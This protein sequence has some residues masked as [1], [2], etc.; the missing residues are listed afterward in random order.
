MVTSAPQADPILIVLAL[1]VGLIIGF[2]VGML[3]GDR[4]VDE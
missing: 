4:E 3:A 1:I 2:M